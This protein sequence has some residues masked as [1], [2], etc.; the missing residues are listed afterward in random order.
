MIVRSGKY[1]MDEQSSPYYSTVMYLTVKDIHK[2][3]LGGYKCVS[4]NSM[5]EAEG[6]IRLYGK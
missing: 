6:T 3:D 2:I 4:K 5:G 1:L